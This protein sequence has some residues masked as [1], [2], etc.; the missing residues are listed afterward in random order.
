MAL[1]NLVSIGPIEVDY[2]N[3]GLRWLSNPTSYIWPC[4]IEGT[5][6]TAEGQALLELVGNPH[7]NKATID[8]YTGVLES[9]EMTGDH[10]APLSGPYLLSDFELS[11]VRQLVFGG[12]VAFSLAAALVIL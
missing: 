8:G 4:R 10:L 6:L 5:V 2:R 7:A 11:V 9:I 3:P 1:G 12:R